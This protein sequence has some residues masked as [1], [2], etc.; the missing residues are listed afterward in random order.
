MGIEFVIKKTMNL[1]V[2][3]E[4]FNF[5]NKFAIKPLNFSNLNNE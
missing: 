3:D 4:H 2:R 1:F 5:E